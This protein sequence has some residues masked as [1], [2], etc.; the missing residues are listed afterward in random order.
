MNPIQLE[1]VR[2]ALVSSGRKDD[3][4]YRSP[5]TLH[6]LWNE[7]EF[8]LANRKPA[9]DLTAAE[10]GQVK[11]V[12]HRKKVLWDKVAE[13]VR[14]GWSAHDA[15]N[16]MY[17]VYGESS[18]VTQIINQMRRDESGKSRLHHSSAIV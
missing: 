5:R 6:T 18:S 1:D 11:Y 12:Y 10:R 4:M 7:Y 13:M 2:R 8:G 3:F 9:K 15:C 17:E 14:S 16:R